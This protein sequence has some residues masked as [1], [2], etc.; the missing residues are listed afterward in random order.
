MHL[1][2]FCQQLHGKFDPISN[3]QTAVDYLAPR[4][5]DLPESWF[6]EPAINEVFL[7]LR[8][9]K[10]ADRIRK[11]LKEFH[12]KH[13]QHT[14]K[15]SPK[16]EPDHWKNR[17]QILATEWDNTAAIARKVR[18]CTGHPMRYFLLHQ[19]ATIL[20]KHAPQHLGLIPPDVLQKMQQNASPQLAAILQPIPPGPAQPT[21]TPN[22]QKDAV[23]KQTAALGPKYLSPAQLD[24]ANPLPHGLKRAQSPLQTPAP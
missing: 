22:Q 9:L 19:L 17:E 24:I 21:R 1:E 11:T 15:T 13:P 6:T 8:S 20:A 12:A 7:K 2:T 3:P 23:A 18:E 10:S 5:H 4:L 16:S 14:P